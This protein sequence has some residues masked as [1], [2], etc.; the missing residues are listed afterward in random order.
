MKT[1]HTKCIHIKR[2]FEEKLRSRK[3]S[4][5]NKKIFTIETTTKGIDG[6]AGEAEHAPRV[7]GR[8][9]QDQPHGAV[10]QLRVPEAV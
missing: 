2:L 5:K 10:H 7:A 8:H 3:I 9:G 6:P 1:G 4:G